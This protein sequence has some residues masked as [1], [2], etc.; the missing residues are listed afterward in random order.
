[1]PEATQQVSLSSSRLLLLIA[2]QYLNVSCIYMTSSS[3]VCFQA[4]EENE[5]IT[6]RSTATHFTNRIFGRRNLCNFQRMDFINE[7]FLFSHA[8]IKPLITSIKQLRFNESCQAPLLHALGWG[9][10]IRMRPVVTE[11]EHGWTRSPF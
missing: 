10:H 5:I 4:P 11:G 6:D 3:D 9:S 7:K 1:M 2:A 8:L